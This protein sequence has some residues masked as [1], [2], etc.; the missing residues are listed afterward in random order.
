MLNTYWIDY[1]TF[2]FWWNHSLFATPDL[3]KKGSRP[4]FINYGVAYTDICW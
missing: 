3:G 1:L 2:F 4:H